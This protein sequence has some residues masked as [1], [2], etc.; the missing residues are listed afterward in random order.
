MLGTAG[1]GGEDAPAAVTARPMVLGTAQE[2]PDPHAR[3]TMVE[4]AGEKGTRLV[5]VDLATGRRRVIAR[6]SA[7]RGGDVGLAGPAFSPSGD[8]VAATTATQSAD[9]RRMTE[10][11]VAPVDGRDTARRV[12]GVRLVDVD[13]YRPVWTPDGRAIAVPHADDNGIDLIEVRSGRRRNL[14]SQAGDG[15]AFAPDGKTYTFNG[16]GGIWLGD[17]SSGKT[18]RIARDAR[19]ATWSPDSQRLAYL[20]TRDHNGTFAVSERPR[21]PADEIYL[22]NR[23]GGNPK[24][25]TTTTADESGPL[26]WTVDGNTIVFSLFTDG[27][28]TV[29]AL[30]VAHRCTAA[31]TLDVGARPPRGDLEDWDIRAKTGLVTEGC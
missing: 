3:T 6:S 19:D 8:Y 17:A 22:A 16:P 13:G 28:L 24:R 30:D 1:C 10:V 4:S 5:V 9:G 31:L 20:S 26:R 12:P 27:R 2:Q 11:I 29:R 7:V 25:V 18:R 15:V 14:L 21:Q 23:D